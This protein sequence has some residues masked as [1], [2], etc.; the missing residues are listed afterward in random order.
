MSFPDSEENGEAEVGWDGD[1]LVGGRTG[2]ELVFLGSARLRDSCFIPS[3]PSVGAYWALSPL[4]RGESQS[5]PCPT[6]VSM[7]WFRVA[8]GSVLHG[9]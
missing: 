1:A 9:Q 4:R 7:C 2:T 8:W 5:H 3:S 6:L